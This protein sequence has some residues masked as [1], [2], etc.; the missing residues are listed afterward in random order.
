VPISVALWRAREA[1]QRIGHA[2]V[3]DDR[4]TTFAIAC[5][6]W[7]GSWNRGTTA[8]PPGMED[9]FSR[10][11]LTRMGPRGAKK[12]RRPLLRCSLLL[13]GVLGLAGVGFVMTDHAPGGGA[14]GAM[15]ASKMTGDAADESPFYAPLSLCGNGN[16]C[17]E[18]RKGDESQE[19]LHHS[20]SNQ[21]FMLTGKG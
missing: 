6:G 7:I 3:F 13:A 11:V 8:N 20:N 15:M 9:L 18:G 19:L 17:Q 16:A 14:S 5:P 10:F 12:G 4:F 2:Y 1:F 21:V